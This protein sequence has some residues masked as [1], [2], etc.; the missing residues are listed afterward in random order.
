V[1]NLGPMPRRLLCVHGHFYQPPRENPWIEEV[2]VQDS[3]APFHDW[4]E[5]IT[6]ECYGPNGAARIKGAQGRIS[7]IV[8]NYLHLSF[9]FG[10]T[11][12]AWLERH[13]PEVYRHILEADAR[14][15][16]ERGH[17]NAIAQGYNHAILPLCS[18]RD[19]RTQVRW[20]I[21]DFRHRFQREPEGMWLPETA[22]DLATLQALADE[23]LKFTVLSPYQAV[24]VRP[25]GGEWKDARNAQFDP[26]MPY[27]VKLPKGGTLSVFFY[28]GPIARAVA[29]GEGL[30]SGDDLVR[31]LETG[32]NPGRSHD[33]VLTVAV[34]GE[35]FGHHKKGGDEV[36]AAALRKLAADPRTELINLGQALEL[37]PPSWEAEIVEGASWSCAHGIERWRSDC[38]CQG[39]GQPGWR[40][41]WRAPLRA[42]LDGLRDALGEL[43]EREA[44]KLLRDP[45]QARE[46]LIDLVLD[47]E[48]KHAEAFVHRHAARALSR[49]ERVRA[50]QL[51]EM[52][53]QAMLMY[54]SCGWFFSE[55]SGLETVQILKYAARALQLARDSTGIDLEPAFRQALAK[56]PSNVAEIGDGGRV[57]ED[58]VKPSV[59][60]L[61]G[62]AAHFAIASIVD[63]FPRRDR[64]FCYELSASQRRSEDAGTATLTVARVELKSVITHEQ[65]D[66]TT[67]VLHFSGADFRCGIRPYDAR[68]QAALAPKVFESFAR[69]SLAQIV[70][71]IDR[72]FPGRDY[73]LRD[74][75]LDERRAVAEKLLRE[76]MGRY[77]SDYL[78]IYESNRRLI[79]FL[80]ELN[81]PV[82][83]PLQ[84]A[85]DVAVTREALQIARGMA[86][87]KL[88]VGA[89]R[90]D[91]L[92]VMQN[93]RRLGARID[94]AALRLP[95][96][97]A[98]QT[99]FERALRG[100]RDDALAI[101]EVA[102][103][104]GRL[105]MHLDLW[106]L[107]N[108]LWDAMRAGTSLLDR[109]GLAPLAAALW[110]D[111]A[112]LST[113]AQRTPPAGR[114]LAASA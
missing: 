70:R 75:F 69:L 31:R 11:L 83:R 10:P 87:G 65:H 102:E 56:A 111:E 1:P 22:A 12:L 35:T 36:L 97:A 52:Q 25:P 81:S 32:F 79:E 91:L 13:S 82:P 43:Y 30:Q 48:R 71:E 53:R 38:G 92:T 6:A 74:L 29:F 66:F 37:C 16:N 108:A 68:A 47:P 106:D 54:T 33:E 63:G 103:I 20:G 40:Q 17:G 105:G 94:L 90:T 44:G 104:G 18:P 55:L 80:R 99:H 78:T 98:M 27:L 45:W 7:D 8:N 2:E 72:E 107:Q 85:A 34:D 59:V 21:A 110:I 89:A 49:E 58:L 26:T 19:L 9:N 93:A 46:E 77:E 95:F 14:S 3:A 86:G 61:E 96:H 51:L 113:R 84:V 5:R 42:A 23:G 28:D 57:Y 88:D 15:V 73:S 4:N 109:E 50:L 60:S 39:N 112:A 41:H 24:R 67:C 101:A 76:T 64:V 114:A 62:V 100:S